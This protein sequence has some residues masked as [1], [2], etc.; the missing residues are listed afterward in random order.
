[1]CVCV[2]ERERHG[3]KGERGRNGS[4]DETAQLVFT[5]NTATGA[6]IKI[7]KLD[8]AGKRQEV[9]KNETLKLVGKDN[10]HEIE[11]ALDEAF[12]AGIASVFEPEDEEEEV[13][14]SEE[15]TELR[16]VLL[17][18]IVGRNVRRRLQRR[19]VQRLILSQ[20]L[21]H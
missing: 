4:A 10:F 16:R 9:Q 13:A 21:R 15:E 18:G 11:S 12:E 1:M 2:W 5:V 19:L 17:V 20:T 14:E 3:A 8:A 7:E 6:V